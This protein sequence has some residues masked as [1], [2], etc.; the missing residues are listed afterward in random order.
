MGAT[1]SGT[2][3]TTVSLGIQAW[4]KA[5]G[6]RVAP[7]KVGP[8]F[9]DPGLHTKV[10]GAVSYNLDSWML[11]KAYNRDLFSAKS[12][13]SDIAVVE[14]VMGLF[15]GYDALSETGSTAQMAKWLDLPVLLVVSAKGKARSAAA[16]VKGFE[17]FDP[18][19]KFAGV[20]FAQAGSERHYHYLRDAV[21][22]N[23]TTPCLGY[24]PKN[25]KIVMPERHL[26]LVTADEMPIPQETLDIL[27]S[28]VDTHLDMEKLLAGLP[29]LS[30][31][32]TDDRK[33]EVS[34]S[35]TTVRS[36]R[37]AV[38]RDKAFCFY[39]PDNIEILQRSG[40]EIVYFSPLTAESLPEDI[41]GIYFGGGYPELNAAQLSAKTELLAQVRN[42]SLDGM[43]IY[44][45]CGGFMYLC[46]NLSDMDG[47]DGGSMC[48]I[49]DFDIKMSG[50]LRSLGYREV[51]TKSDTLLG[52]AGTKI[53]GHE[54][55]YSSIVP[56]AE[57]NHSGGNGESVDSVY[58]VAS[59]AGQDISLEGFQRR[60]TLGSYLHV[61][62]G[63]NPEAAASFVA[64]CS[65]YKNTR[66]GSAPGSTE[67]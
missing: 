19:L 5:K 31:T 13:G 14:G 8:D 15:D 47:N 65:R 16:I 50:R 9:I 3:K 40:A 4:M 2:G 7:F 37:I 36:P 46:R 54:F 28:M 34:I 38:A 49:F 66:T 51:T 53:R 42:A 35:T 29:D 26:G 11:P 45:E 52:P 55:H 67:G 10:S 59:R 61:H 60:N 62:F 48:G 63:S 39:Y 30:G 25:E 27:V 6:M 41:D 24:L 44:G 21:E 57:E 56:E 23:C 18:D 1:G 58:N 43:P 12:A 22:Q 20:I 33:T 64:C 17:T 32:Q